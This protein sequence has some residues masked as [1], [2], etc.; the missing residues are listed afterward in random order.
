MENAGVTMGF[1][2]I[3]RFEVC[4]P[5]AAKVGKLAFGIVVPFKLQSTWEVAGLPFY[6]IIEKS[7]APCSVMYGPTQWGVSPPYCGCALSV[8]A[9]VIASSMLVRTSDFP[10]SIIL[11]INSATCFR[12][13]TYR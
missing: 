9:S 6:K 8:T 2:V 13:T 1:I 4:E 10:R 12:L 11:I 5:V 7:V 3:E